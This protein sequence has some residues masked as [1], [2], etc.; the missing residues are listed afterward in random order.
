M[1]ARQFRILV[2]LTVV[3]GFLGGGASNLLFRG[4][5]AAAQ[6]ATAQ[7]QDEVRARSFVLVDDNGKKRARLGVKEG[8]A[9]FALFDAE[10]NPRIMLLTGAATGSQLTIGDAAGKFQ[11]NLSVSADNAAALLLNDPAEKQRVG[12]LVTPEGASGVQFSD[13]AGKQRAFLGADTDGSPSAQLSDAAGKTL[14]KAP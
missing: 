4:A 12:L 1:T 5:P 7:V 6:P 2:A 14:W 3:A 13:E 10:E 11:A 8:D 9:A